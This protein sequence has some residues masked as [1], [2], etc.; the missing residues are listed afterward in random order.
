MINNGNDVP[1]DQYGDMNQYINYLFND[2]TSSGNDIDNPFKTLNIQSS[3]YDVEN[4]KHMKPVYSGNHTSE[5]TSMHLNVQ[6]LPAKFDKL[7]D[8]LSELNEQ[9][10]HID[11]ILLCETFLNKNN[12]NMYNLP[13]YNFSL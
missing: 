8:L 13:G 9:N 6:S 7:K 5:L 1:V 12:L 11:L 4:L 3:Y 2:D 10:I